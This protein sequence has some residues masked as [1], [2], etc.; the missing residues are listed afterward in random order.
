[1]RELKIGEKTIQIRGTALALL[2]YKREFKSDLLKDMINM[3]GGD[4]KTMGA[5]M[6]PENLDTVTILQMVWAM[7]KAGEFGKGQFPGFESWLHQSG[8]EI[9]IFSEEFLT[10][11]INEMTEGFFRNVSAPAAGT[12][13]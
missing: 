10:D 13:K 3:F 12:A 8:D 5:D 9:N 4:L 6:G 7:A 2:F 1:M 11:V